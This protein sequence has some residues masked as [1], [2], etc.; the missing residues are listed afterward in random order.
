MSFFQ[1]RMPSVHACATKILESA[2]RIGDADFL[3]LL[4]KSDPLKGVC[5][6]R[7]LVH[8]VSQSDVPIV[9]IL[10]KN[11]ADV[12]TPGSNRYQFPALQYATFRDQPQM[13]QILLKAGANIDAITAHA[14][15]NTALSRAVGEN[16]VELVRI[17]VTAGANLDICTVGDLSAIDYSAFYCDDELHQLLLSGSGKNHISITSHGA[18]N[19]AKEGIQALSGYLAERDEED[20]NLKREV[21]E[22]ALQHAV[23]NED[24]QAIMSLLRIGVAP[25]SEIQLKREAIT[26]LSTAIKFCDIDTVKI[27]LQA[28]GNVY[29]PSVLSQAI[30]SQKTIEM[31][32]F[33]LDVGANIEI[34]GGEPLGIAVDCENI[35][36]VQF[37]LLHGANVNDPEIGASTALQLAIRN[38]NIELLK[39]LLDAGA[40]VDASCG[41]GDQTALG[42]AVKTID[43]SDLRLEIVRI[44]LAAG[45]DVNGPQ[46]G[47]QGASILQSAI[48][49]GDENLVKIL[50]Q[51]GA[52]VNSLPKGKKGRSPIQAAAER[53][54]IPLVKLLL[55]SGADV[56]ASAGRDN[57]RTAI[58]AAS[59]AVNP[60]MDLIDFLIDSGAYIHAPAGLS[61]GA[62]ALQGAAIRGHIKIAL[63]FLEAGADVN[64]TESILYGETALDGAAEHGRL[65]MVQMLLNAGAC[66]DSTKA[67]QFDRAMKLAWTNGH[68]AVA[69]LLEQA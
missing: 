18:W 52:D 50:L 48:C 22:Y 23:K 40:D 56:N 31:L 64:A 16:M 27:L 7:H 44:L 62:T 10:L 3:E 68:F 45:A 51:E 66:G 4:I 14:T 46:S 8:A 20:S 15:Y 19:A 41:W 57:G 34:S 35:E 59:S 38:Q 60:T 63:K 67:H 1:C 13:I 6:G 54:S 32:R 29:H 36:A 33:L 55:E 69:K 39:I 43:G 49:M 9:Q 65:D 17:L 42:A 58:Q 12:D 24:P 21:L 47:R 53:G 30:Y 11:G 2:L 28:G 61:G 5:G 26:P 25:N 37:L